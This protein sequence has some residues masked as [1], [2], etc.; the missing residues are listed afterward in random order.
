MERRCTERGDLCRDCC[1]FR[2]CSGVSKE[3][4][5]GVSSRPP[6]SVL[7]VVWVYGGLLLPGFPSCVCSFSVPC[8]PSASCCA[9][10]PLVLLTFFPPCASGLCWNDCVMH[11]SLSPVHGEVGEYW[12]D[13]PPLWAPAQCWVAWPCFAVSRFPGSCAHSQEAMVVDV[14]A[15][16]VHQEGVVDVIQ[17]A[18]DVACDEPLRAHPGLDD[19]VAGWVASPLRSASVA[20]CG[21]LWVIRGFQNGAYDVLYHFL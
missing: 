6:P 2:P 20:V 15:E 8:L 4:V 3:K 16:D 5:L 1:G 13:S 19:L 12:A 14:L 9:S 17:A 11:T 18:F 10:S 21:A 7:V